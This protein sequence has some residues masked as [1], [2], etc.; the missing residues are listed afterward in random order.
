MN[1]PTP[2]IG[3]KAGEIAPVVL[4]PGDPLRAK[5][6]ADHYLEHP[7]CSPEV[8]GMLG[9]TGTYKG[10][11]VSVQGSGMGCPSMGIYSHELYAFYGVETIIRVGSAGA[12]QDF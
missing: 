7:V 1:T 3:A 6:I 8:R 12:L 10:K 11:P 2:H 9:F 4:M 5:W